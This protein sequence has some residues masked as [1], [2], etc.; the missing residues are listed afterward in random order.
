MGLTQEGIH[1]WLNDTFRD[2]ASPVYLA[3]FTASGEVSAPS[4]TRL[5]IT[6]SAP[7]NREITNDAEVKF[8]IAAEEWGDITGAGIFDSET[9]GIR[10]DESTITDARFIRSNDQ[11]YVPPGNM[12]VRIRNTD[13][14]AKKNAI[15]LVNASSLPAGDK[16]AIINKI[17]A[18]VV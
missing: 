11:F 5:P 2:S 1:K 18:M 4:Y 14:E 6:F 7:A 3:L 9:A 12:I 8:P 17:E 10:L 16:T 15:D 13:L